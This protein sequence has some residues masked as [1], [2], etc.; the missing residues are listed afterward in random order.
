[1]PSANSR[2][3]LASLLGRALIAWLFVPSG[4]SKLLGFAG[5]SGYIASKGM[6]FPELCAAAAIAAELGLGLLILLG[7]QA[8]YA[9][10]GLAVFVAVITPIFHNYWDLPPA[11]AM[12]QKQSFNKN[13]AIIGGLML[14]AAFGPGRWSLQRKA[15][16]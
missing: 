6:P 4:I 11:Q 8:R 12:L 1:M 16:G 7:W 3:D 5:I 15:A 13:V 9:A 10:L 14:L 2:S